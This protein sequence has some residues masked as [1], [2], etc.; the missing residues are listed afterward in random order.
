M[1]FRIRKALPADGRVIAHVQVATWRTTYPGI[2]PDE[3]LASLSVEERA[4]NWSEL[5]ANASDDPPAFVAEDDQRVFGFVSGGRLRQPISEYDGELYAIYL[6]R[7]HQRS[8]IGRALV[9]TL[10]DALR[11]RN[12]R[13][14]AVWVLEQ[15][16]AV[17]FYKALGGVLIAHQTIEISG[18]SLP[19]IAFGWPDLKALFGA[20]GG[21]TKGS[22]A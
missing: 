14:M 15:N 7:E 3:F 6:L 13:S 18:V 20:T 9:Q 2:V 12:M 17:A 21:A 4:K 8:G 16:P 5:L 1:E 19:E 11:A 22:I 10:A